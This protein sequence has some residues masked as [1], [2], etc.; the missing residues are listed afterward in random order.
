M[1]IALL[2]VLLASAP[3][4]HA[5]LQGPALM[6]TTISVA[7]GAPS[8]TIN[9]L[10]YDDQGFLMVGTT[11]GLARYDGARFETLLSADHEGLDGDRIIALH[12]DPS[13]RVWIGAAQA[14][15]C[16]LE[17]DRF[18]RISEAEDLHSVRQFLATKDGALWLVGHKLAR[19]HDDELEVFGEESGLPGGPLSRLVEDGEG[20]LWIATREGV[21]KR[22]ADGFQCVDHRRSVWLTTDFEGYVWSQTAS[23][24]VVSLS[25]PPAETLSLGQVRLQDEVPHK[26]ATRLLATSAGVFAM[27]RGDS[28]EQRLRIGTEGIAQLDVPRGVRCLLQGSGSVRDLWIGTE[29]DALQYVETSSTVL[30]DLHQDFPR[31]AAA[32][33]HPLPGGDALILGG[34][35]QVA[36]LLDEKGKRTPIEVIDPSD[37]HSNSSASTSGVTWLSTRGGLARFEDGI[38]LP[39][40]RWR[41]PAG[42]IIASPDG[43]VWLV[44]QG[45]LE[46]VE[47]GRGSSGELASFPLPPSGIV[48]LCYAR[49]A[50]IA[51]SRSEL[52]RLDTKS[53]EWM[54]IA[55][56]GQASVRHLR[57]GHGGEIWISTYG[58]GLFRLGAAGPLEHWS[59]AAGLPDPFLAWIAPVDDS[60]YLWVHSN[61]G[62]IRASTASLD[63]HAAGKTMTIEAQTFRVPEANGALGAVLANGAIALPTLEGVAIFDR[64]SLPPPSASPRVLIRGPYV[65]GAPMNE[66]GHYRDSVNVLYEFTAPIFP[67]SSHA[68]FQY[69]MVEFDERWID[70]GSARAARFPNL[71][72]GRYTL[73][74]RARTPTST[75][76]TPM[77][78]KTLVI[79]PYWFE[80]AWVRWSFAGAALLAV[81]RLFFLRNRSLG[82]RNFALTQE[83]SRRKAMEARLGA[84]ERRFRRLFHTAPSAILSWT[85]SGSL[86]DRNERADELFAWGHDEVVEGHPWELFDDEELGKDAI[87]RAFVECEDFSLVAMTRVG[88]FQVKRCRWHF[89]PTRSESGEV[90]SIIAMISD[91]SRRD[92]DARTLADL[93][94]NLVRAEESERSRIARELHDDLSQRLA[95]L[96][97]EAHLL[98]LKRPSNGPTDESG[99]TETV[100]SFQSE[101]ENVA[102]H[103]HTLSRQLHPTIVDD[104]GLVTA[105]RSECS[106]RNRTDK[107]PVELAIDSGVEEPPKETALALFRIAQEAIR[108]ASRHSGATSIHVTLEVNGDSLEL[109]VRDNGKGIGRAESPA[110]KGG[111]GMKSMQERAR[112]AG[113]DFWVTSNPSGGT[114][115]TARVPRHAEGLRRAMALRDD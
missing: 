14:A 95:A 70:A 61:A 103:L 11:A 81:L 59:K 111:I 20:S 77:R 113:G 100:R 27:W 57:P 40:P 34:D 91:L 54:T 2:L 80:R 83:V 29:L 28:P 6:R 19:F 73:E 31:W 93:R 109:S 53:G 48:A 94:E 16:V 78:S 30:V 25:G 101:I 85:P 87:Q 98:D 92:K 44:F 37:Y 42:P 104:L 47:A 71:P 88:D 96:A 86:A 32:H 84:S 74:V 35:R 5:A 41:G 67:T 18:R 3:L 62:V 45:R 72:N 65:N 58:Q 64:S 15:P 52:L 10:G 21:F 99:M 60:G 97:I 43:D 89:A 24:D 76:S 55:K 56:L 4:A 38:L 107:A 75:W 82:R 50:P 13:G 105:L 112:L 23:G 49:G 9:A 108:N 102:T 46:Q 68:S 106:R 7:D 8:N 1:R 36:F 115:V 51:A 69:R 110:G 90:T 63:A 17:N 22:D 114:C 33:V 12:R 79:A 39:D 26:G 66:A